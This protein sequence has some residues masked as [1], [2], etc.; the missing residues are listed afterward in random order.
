[1]LLQVVSFLE[2]KLMIHSSYCEKQQSFVFEQRVIVIL[3]V[4][5]A[6]KFEMKRNPFVYL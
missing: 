4:A 6:T 3:S 5:I 1:M 2:K